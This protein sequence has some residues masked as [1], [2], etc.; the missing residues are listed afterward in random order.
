MSYYDKSKTLSCPRINS[1]GSQKET[2]Y[3]ILNKN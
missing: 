3:S 2:R 1:K